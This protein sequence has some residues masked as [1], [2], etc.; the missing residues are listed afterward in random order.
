MAEHR[1]QLARE[2]AGLSIGNA[3]RILNL[4]AVSLRA[5]EHAAS[6]APDDLIRA[7]ADHYGV[8]VAWLTGAIPRYD[9]EAAHRLRRPRV[10]QGS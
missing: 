5:L 3:A 8:N 6:T 4:P 9:Y 2:R 10:L 1:Y 7:M